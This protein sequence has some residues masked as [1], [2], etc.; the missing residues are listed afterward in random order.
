MPIAFGERL[1]QRSLGQV[2]RLSKH[3]AD[4][5]PVEVPKLPG[6]QHL[7]QVEH[8]EEVELEITHVALVVTHDRRLTCGY[9]ICEPKPSP[10]YPS[11]TAK[12]TGPRAGRPAAWAARTPTHDVAWES[13]WRLEVTTTS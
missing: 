1:G 3:L 6:G 13:G 12:W 11:V 9:A 10:V 5:R 8:L 2:R 4:R 7:L